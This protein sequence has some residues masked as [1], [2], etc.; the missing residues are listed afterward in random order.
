M[1]NNLLFFSIMEANVVR[2]LGPRVV[3]QTS[4]TVAATKMAIKQMTATAAAEAAKGTSPLARD[5]TATVCCTI[6]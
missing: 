4:H 2:A 3:V 6:P 1:L 5:K